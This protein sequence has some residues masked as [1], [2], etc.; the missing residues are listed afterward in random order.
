MF[1]ATTRVRNHRL[2][3]VCGAT[4]LLFLSHSAAQAEIHLAIGSRFEPYRYTKNFFPNAP[5]SLTAGKGLYAANP[6]FQTTSLAP[7]LGAFFAQRYGVLLGLDLGWSRLSSDSKIGAAPMD[8]QSSDSYLQFGFSLGGKLYLR[9]LGKDRVVPYLYVDIFKYFA[10]VSTNSPS[11]TG[12]QASAQASLASP[13]GG[14]LSIGAEYFLGENFSFGAEI[15]GLR[16]SHV[17]AEYT[18]SG[19]THS[20]GFT[21]LAMYSGITMNYRFAV[22]SPSRP[23]DDRETDRRRPNALPPPPVLPPPTPEA[24]D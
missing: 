3:S 6:N 17:S 5:A 9:D 15:F 12:E 11:V 4:S 23:S 21:A 13:V 7:Y 8:P 14:T 1:G 24:I 20:A 19:T 10:S 22:G 2:L 18:D 16:V